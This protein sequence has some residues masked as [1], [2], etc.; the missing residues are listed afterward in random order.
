RI[1]LMI[2]GFRFE[3]RVGVDQHQLGVDDL[4]SCV[5]HGV[6]DGER[7]HLG[8]AHTSLGPAL[9]TLIKENSLPRQNL[10][11]LLKMQAIKP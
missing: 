2:E 4:Y 7:N 10:G 11:A 9:A 1:V 8:F 3:T 6:A 5:L